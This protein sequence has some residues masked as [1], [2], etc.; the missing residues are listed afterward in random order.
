MVVQVDPLKHWETGEFFFPVITKAMNLPVFVKNYFLFAHWG[1]QQCW[2]VFCVANPGNLSI[3]F[4]LGVS[5]HSLKLSPVPAAGSSD[6]C[7]L[8]VSLLG[9]LSEL[10]SLKL[11]KLKPTFE[12]CVTQYKLCCCQCWNIH[13]CFM[14]KTLRM[15]G[16]QMGIPFLHVVEIFLNK[17]TLICVLCL[18]YL[19]FKEFFTWSKDPW[20]NWLVEV[21][22]WYLQGICSWTITPQILKIVVKWETGSGVFPFQNPHRVEAAGLWRVQVGHVWGRPTLRQIYRSK[23]CR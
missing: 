11:E 15:L 2:T 16:G 12:I 10:A 9:D 3:W 7:V 19:F 1:Q 8:M 5:V 18:P 14:F 20:N 21:Y 23:I 6:Q 22:H 17:Q 4:M 13:I